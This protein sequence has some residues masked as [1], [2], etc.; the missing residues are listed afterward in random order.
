LWHLPVANGLFFARQTGFA[1]DGW[2]VP[3][4]LKIFAFCRKA[5]VWAGLKTPWPVGKYELPFLPGKCG[6]H[7]AD[8]GTMPALVV[9]PQSFKSV[10]V[11]LVL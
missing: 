2:L 10:L 9:A 1:P 6:L 5:C 11:F 3:E 7:Y 4:L 8:I